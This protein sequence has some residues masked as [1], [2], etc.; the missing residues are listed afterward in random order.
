[1]SNILVSF[2]IVSRGRFEGLLKAIGSIINTASNTQR[3]EILI[4]LDEDDVMSLSRLEELPKDKIII[5]T[6]IGEKYGYEFLHKYVNELCLQANGEFFAWFNDDCVIK[7]KGW[8]DIIS[9]YKGQIVSFY[10]NHKGTGSG[11]IF[12]IIPRKVFEILGHFSLSQQVDTWQFVVCNKSGIEIKRDDIVFVHNR[13]S[14]VKEY[15]SDGDRKAVHKKTAKV[16][17]NLRK[18]RFNDVNKIRKFLGKEPYEKEK[19]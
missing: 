5:K 4:R 19:I 18:K 15:I 8:D 12:P 14:G 9:K 11:N 2:L 10:P 6:F 3:I 7:S 13:E 17:K 1:M 16:W